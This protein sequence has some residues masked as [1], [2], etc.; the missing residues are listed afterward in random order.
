MF[1]SAKYRLYPTKSQAVLL[2]KHIGAARFVYNL[3]LE[4]KQVA[5]ASGKVNLTCFDLINQIPELKKEC[6]WLKEVNSQTLQLSVVN[7]D[8]AYTNFFKGKSNFPKFKS[9]RNGVQSF[10]VQQN[11]KILNCSICIPKFKPIKAVIH[12]TIVGKIKG[13]TISRTS[14]GKYFASVLFE[15]NEVAPAKP[16]ITEANTVGVDL[17]I[18]D[19]AI[20]SNGEK[21]ANP[22]FLKRSISKLKF[23][24]RK[25]SKYNG[26]RTRQKL[27]LIHEK[28]ANQRSNFLHQITKKLVVEN[29]TIALEDLNVSGMMKNHKLAQS[30]QD[31]SWGKFGELINY[32][33]E[34]YGSNIIKIGRFEPSSRMSDCGQV[35]KELTLKD[36]VWTCKHC[37]NT[38]DRDIQAA[39]NIKKFALRNHVSGT[40]TKTRNELPTLVGVLTCEA[41]KG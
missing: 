27:A 33:A 40:D 11:V 9:K 41:P 1:K 12:R 22:K 25:Y 5:Y 29:Q 26:N 17:G 28:V 37:G 8:T 2:D 39:K 20:T 14:T 4:T 13:A 32:K 36:R 24:H 38:Y 3:A 23:V 21:F 18:K 19:F 10:R 34:W 16:K 6:P 15:T 7:M 30:I 35:N 31:V